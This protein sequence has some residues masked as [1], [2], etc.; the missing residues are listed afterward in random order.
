[1]AP[2][3]TEYRLA[4]I[5]CGDIVGYSRLIGS[6]ETAAVRLVTAYR[7]EIE[8]LV[9]IHHGQLV[10]FTGDNFLAHFSSSVAAVECAM[11]I[12]QILKTR[13]EALPEG[14]RM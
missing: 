14:Q 6:D 13:N 4:A 3:G 12:Q 1:M 7:E 11:D 5:I 9:P 10:D 8:R 2:E